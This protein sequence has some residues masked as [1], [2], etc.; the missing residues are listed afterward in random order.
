M[1]VTQY[2]AT[3][4]EVIDCAECGM[5]FGMMEGY[6]RRRRDDGVTFYCP[7]GHR[8][9]YGDTTIKRLKR[10]VAALD[11]EADELRLRVKGAK[12]ATASAKAAVTRSRN[13]AAKGVC[14]FCNRTVKQM[15]SHVADKHP[16]QV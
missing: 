13:R 10:R 5:P 12:R 7:S 4:V 2:Y 8:N 3:T 9:V 15:A 6:I 1:A 16:E 14:Q 11:S